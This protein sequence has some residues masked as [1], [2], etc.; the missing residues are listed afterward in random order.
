ML[1]YPTLPPQHRPLTELQKVAD[2]KFC[3]DSTAL[4]P[5]PAVITHA[6]SRL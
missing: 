4:Y 5:S 6:V 3:F 1:C 2:M